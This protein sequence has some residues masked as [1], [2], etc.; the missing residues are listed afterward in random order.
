MSSI[1]IYPEHAVMFAGQSGAGKSLF[2]LQTIE[3]LF[4]EM[5]EGTKAKIYDTEGRLELQAENLMHNR[6]N[7]EILKRIDIRSITPS[8]SGIEELLS[9]VG[10]ETD[11]E[12]KKVKIKIDIEEYKDISKSLKRFEDYNILALDSFSYLFKKTFGNVRPNYAPRSQFIS[13]LMGRIR[14]IMKKSSN[15]IFFGTSHGGIAP[16][17]FGRD[18]YWYASGSLAFSFPQVFFFDKTA[19]GHIILKVQKDSFVP[20]KIFLST[21]HIIISRPEVSALEKGEINE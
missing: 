1:K 11:V 14:E 5:G 4:D 19:K 13:M 10:I 21:K 15:K 8:L 20:K 9:E 12:R 18:T 3:N 2:L 16:T 6:G 17:S 7:S